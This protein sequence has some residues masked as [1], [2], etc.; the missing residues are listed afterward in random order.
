MDAKRKAE[1]VRIQTIL[2]NVLGLDVYDYAHHPAPQLIHHP[3]IVIKSGNVI[4]PKI[5]KKLKDNSK[6]QILAVV[7]TPEE[8]KYT[9]ARVTLSAPA[10][11]RK[12]P[13]NNTTLS[14]SVSSAK[15]RKCRT[16]HE[17]IT[18]LQTLVVE[19][20]EFSKTFPHDA[21]IAVKTNDYYD[22]HIFSVTAKLPENPELFQKR[23]AGLKKVDDKKTAAAIYKAKE[24]KF[25]SADARK[26]KAKDMIEWLKKNKDVVGEL[27]DEFRPIKLE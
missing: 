6:E 3:H 2:T 26:K 5:A 11:E 19:T 13:H 9:L 7:L 8:E 23:I 25:K 17:L 15:M 16:P 24:A 20:I 1:E 4:M 14:Y 10:A 27:P 18:M 12:G 22:N 21:V